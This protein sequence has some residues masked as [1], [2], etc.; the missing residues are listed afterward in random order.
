MGYQAGFGTAAGFLKKPDCKDVGKADFYGRN[1]S[2]KNA[3]K[4]SFCKCIS[5]YR[6]RGRNK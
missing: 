4:E 1:K 3:E 6:Q 2:R 5:A